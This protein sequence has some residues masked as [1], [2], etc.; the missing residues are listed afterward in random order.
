MVDRNGTPY[1]EDGGQYILKDGQWFCEWCGNVVNG[2]SW[3]HLRSW[4]HAKNLCHYEVEPLPEWAREMLID[5]GWLEESPD[6]FLRR[7]QAAIMRGQPRFRHPPSSPTAHPIPGP[8]PGDGPD[9]GEVPPPAPK[10]KSA[11]PPPPGVVP[12]TQPPAGAAGS[13]AALAA[14][15]DAPPQR[16]E[17]AAGSAAVPPADI[18]Q[19]F[20]VIDGMTLEIEGLKSELAAQ[21]RTVADVTTSMRQAIEGLVEQIAG[22]TLELAAGKRTV[23]DVEMRMWRVEQSGTAADAV[24]QTGVPTP[25]DGD[26]VRRNACVSSSNEGLLECTRPGP[27]SSSV[28]PNYHKK[29]CRCGFL[30]YF[31]KTLGE[32]VRPRP[33]NV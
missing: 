32:S 6:D 14:S 30:A 2:I 1:P 3:G 10:P 18:L 12:R 9:D 19:Q 27:D 16:P 26:L 4:A 25:S 5:K 7:Q 24:W 33:R 23:A 21:K 28:L 11:P 13:A 29:S 8:P 20:A 22:L 31:R 17:G 15:S